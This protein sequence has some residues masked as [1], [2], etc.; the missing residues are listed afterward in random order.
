MLHL[1]AIPL[2]IAAA[3]LL[4]RILFGAKALRHLGAICVGVLL[5]LFVA[6]AAL[7]GSRI[8]FINAPSEWLEHLAYQSQTGSMALTWLLF[9]FTYYALLGAIILCAGAILRDKLTGDE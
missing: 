5:G 3:V 1:L 4:L 7:W 8:R 9:H 2:S 6:Y